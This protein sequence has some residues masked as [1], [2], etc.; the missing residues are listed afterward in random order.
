MGAR[1]FFAFPNVWSAE[2]SVDQRVIEKQS[3]NW[4]RPT[5]SRASSGR[6]CFFP[7][8]T[9][10]PLPA[11]LWARFSHREA[12]ECGLTP[13]P[14]IH[15]AFRFWTRKL[16]RACLLFHACE[17]ARPRLF[18]SLWSSYSGRVFF[19]SWK[20]TNLDDTD[21][22]PQRI[23]FIDFKRKVVRAEKRS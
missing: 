10:F 1:Y 18:T 11:D 3:E 9:C 7:G 15:A 14:L 16:L 2:T 8:H 22:R 12:R 5:S 17:S 6:V 23:R 13:F 4:T 20:L 19:R 21:Y